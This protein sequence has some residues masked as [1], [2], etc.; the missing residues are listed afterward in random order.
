MS[1]LQNWR[2]NAVAHRSA[3]HALNQATSSPGCRYRS[4]ICRLT[5][6]A[7]R[8]VNYYSQLFDATSYMMRMIGNDDYRK[9]LQRAHDDIR[10][11]EQAINEELRQAGYMP[12]GRP[13][14]PRNRTQ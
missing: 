7:A 5:K 9:I 4:G 3:A 1:R 8:T 2:H 11:H 10:Q 14:R 13:I 6:R 12:T